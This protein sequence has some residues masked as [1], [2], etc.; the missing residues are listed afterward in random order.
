MKTEQA[1]NG[2]VADDDDHHLRS[3]AN[4]SS[5]SLHLF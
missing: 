4:S 5:L 3:L 2:F 1:W